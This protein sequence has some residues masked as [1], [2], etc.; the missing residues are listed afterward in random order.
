MLFTHLGEVLQ[1]VR[2]VMG[3]AVQVDPD[4]LGAILPLPVV[5]VQFMEAQIPE[6][7]VVQET[8]VVAVA[9]VMAVQV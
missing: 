4:S 1:T 8:P 5:A 9:A 3:E 6:A 2:V 7:E